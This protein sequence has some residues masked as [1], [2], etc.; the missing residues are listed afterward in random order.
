[1]KLN[2]K[3]VITNKRNNNKR[4]SRPAKPRGDTFLQELMDEAY[5]NHAR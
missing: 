4:T 5:I 3:T 2:K 1:M